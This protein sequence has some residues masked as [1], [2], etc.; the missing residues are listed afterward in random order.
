MRLASLEAGVLLVA[1]GVGMLLCLSY[2]RHR[3]KDEDSALF[4]SFLH[5][6]CIREWIGKCRECGQSWQYKWISP[7]HGQQDAYLRHIVRC[8]ESHVDDQKACL[9]L[10]EMNT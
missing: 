1:P 2:H 9:E 6:D 8:H 3:A 5:A 10:K 4:L 7:K